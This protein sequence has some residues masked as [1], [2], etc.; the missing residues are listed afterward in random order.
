M[1]EKK[2]YIVVVKPGENLTALDSEMS[3]AT[4]SG[5]V[6]SR[7]VECADAQE[8]D[9]RM[10]NWMLT[11]EEAKLLETDSRILGVELP[12]KNDDSVII[13]PMAVQPGIYNKTEVNDGVNWGLSRCNSKVNNFEGINELSDNFRYCMTGEGVDVVIM[14]S[15]IELDHPEF[16]DSVGAARIQ[17][18]DWYAASNG[19]MS[20]TLGAGFYTD[21]GGHGTHVAGIAVGK[22]YGWAKNAHIYSMKIFDTDS[23]GV[24]D[25]CD[26]IKHWH[27]NKGNS[28]PTIVNMSFGYLYNFEDWSG[29]QA[30]DSGQ[31]WDTFTNQM[32]VWN[33][34][35]PN[36][37]TKFEVNFEVDI[38]PSSYA[39]PSKRLS[40]IDAK[41]DQLI[42]A[43]IHITIAGNNNY[44]VQ[45][46]YSDDVN[47]NYN[48]FF[49]RP[50]YNGGAPVYY[51]R[52]SS[53]RA[54][55]VKSGEMIVANIGVFEH[56]NKEILDES[57]ACGEA[58]DI[59]APGTN[60]TSSCSTDT[61]DAAGGPRSVSDYPDDPNFKIIQMTGTSMAAPQVCGVG[62]LYLQFD[63]TL[64][65]A[66]LKKKMLDDAQ[67]GLLHDT[68]W[69]QKDLGKYQFF[70]NT[71]GTRQYRGLF[72]APN[73]VLYNNYAGDV[74]V[75]WV[76]AE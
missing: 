34:G 6:P 56:N 22:T 11:D 29:I 21:T 73:K 17:A 5:V 45:Y 9:T 76:K 19:A 15:G 33:F 43:G 27:N 65:P 4:G 35:D 41:I 61:S 60:I 37:T 38:E 32:D 18:I 49:I 47:D 30:G 44:E 75:K 28:R 3:A 48:D 25:A 14:D 26:L 31:H 42:A 70:S 51:H 52:G 20:G 39:K 1:S 72:G 2:E 64:T 23:L 13:E 66:Q 62:A 8:H 16:K 54:S 67:T 50:S 46:N 36:F 69:D 71:S 40:Y 12:F 7:A 53:P 63:P 59:S 58:I 68:V 24:E 55:T 57:S 74:L 10:T